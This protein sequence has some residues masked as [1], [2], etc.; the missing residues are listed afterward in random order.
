MS[1]DHAHN[2]RNTAQH[3]VHLLRQT[4]LRSHI[5]THNPTPPATSDQAKITHS[6]TQPN[7]ACSVRPSKDHTFIH[8]T[9]HRLLRQTKQGSHIHTHNPTPPAPSDQAKIRH[10]YTQP[11]TACSVRPSKD[12]TF[13]HTTQHRLLRQTKQ[14]SHIHTHSPIPQA[15]ITQSFCFVKSTSNTSDYIHTTQHRQH[16]VF[17]LSDQPAIH[18]TTHTTKYNTANTP[19]SFR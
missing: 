5:H 7:T 10:S 16:S 12:H 4:K 1:F 13:I 15:T 11:N 6:Y 2:P 14:R 18:L 17:V 3:S 9:Q 8:T 19:F